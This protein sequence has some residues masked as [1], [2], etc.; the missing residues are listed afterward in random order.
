MDNGNNAAVIYQIRMSVAILEMSLSARWV[1]HFSGEIVPNC[2][3]TDLEWPWSKCHYPAWLLECTAALRW[4]IATVSGR[5]SQKLRCSRLPYKKVPVH[6]NTGTSEWQSWKL[7]FVALATNEDCATLAWCDRYSENHAV[8]NRDAA[9]WTL[10]TSQEFPADT[11]Q[12]MVAV[13]KPTSY[14]RLPTSVV[15]ELRKVRS[16][17]SWEK[18][19]RHIAA[20]WSCMVSWLSRWTPR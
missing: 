13:V 3:T 7:S 6:S 19:R 1:F 20:T 14:K 5:V 9:F 8:M 10:Q 16:C 18:H 11:V 15:N 2:W 17:L 12:Q 4:Q